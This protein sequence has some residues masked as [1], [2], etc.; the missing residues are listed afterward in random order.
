MMMIRRYQKNTSNFQTDHSGI[1]GLIEGAMQ[2]LKLCMQKTLL[3][4]TCKNSAI[5]ARILTAIEAEGYPLFVAK[6]A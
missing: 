5:F 1:K 4:T 3:A 6:R 2:L